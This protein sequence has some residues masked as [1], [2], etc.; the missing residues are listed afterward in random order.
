LRRDSTVSADPPRGSS[1]APYICG[2]ALEGERGVETVP[3]MLLAELDL[4]MAL[5]D[6]PR[7]ADVGPSVLERRPA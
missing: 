1:R 5:S 6:Q 2:L 3:R 4:T 7:L